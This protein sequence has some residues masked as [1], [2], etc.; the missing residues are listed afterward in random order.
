MRLVQKGFADTDSR[1][2]HQQG[3]GSSFVCLERE[4]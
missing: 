1:D 4:A 2:R 3:W